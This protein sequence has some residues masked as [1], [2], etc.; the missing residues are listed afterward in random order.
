SPHLRSAKSVEELNP[1]IVQEHRAITGSNPC[2]GGTD[3]LLT[4]LSIHEPDSLAKA[5]CLLFCK[6]WIRFKLTGQKA[7]ELSD[8]STSLIDLST[9]KISHRIFELLGIS[10]YRSLLPPLIDSYSIVGHV[11]P[12]VAALTGLCE[13]IPVVAGCIDVVATAIGAGVIEKYDA[14][15]VLGTSCINEYIFDDVAHLGDNNAAHLCYDSKSR[16]ICLMGTMTGMPN[17]EW[18]IKTFFSDVLTDIE[19]TEKLF[20]YLEKELHKTQPGANG[21]IYHP[22][23]STS[24][25][26]FPFCDSHARAG[27]FGIT[28]SCNRLHLLRAVYE[29]LAYSIKDC[30]ADFTPERI[31]LAGGGSNDCVLV[32]IIADCLGVPVI[33]S[34]IKELGARG[35]AII[36]GVGIGIFHNTEHALKE[37]TST[38]RRYN[39][40]PAFTATYNEVYQLYKHIRMQYATSWQMRADMLKKIGIREGKINDTV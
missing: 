29:G 22:Y 16:Y 15:S 25:E 10:A 36:A 18:A 37:C 32:Q 40:N 21:V 3:I 27:F 26:R 5:D 20:R 17:I 34:D 19:D 39:P 11:T 38:N 14:C 28:E 35:A 31:F 1:A 23:I 4:W 8:A 12:Q 7:I 33:V 6:D 2:A 9:G 13:N 24:G 30:F